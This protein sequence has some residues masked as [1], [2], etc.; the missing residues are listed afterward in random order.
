MLI[1][2]PD[3]LTSEQVDQC[4]TILDPVDH[5]VGSRTTEGSQPGRLKEN[6]QLP[7]NL[8]A[9]QEMGDM[10]LSALEQNALF[11]TAALPSR[12]FP[13][14]FHRYQGE[15]LF[16]GITNQAVRQVAGTPLR[17]RTDLS[18]MLFFSDPDEYEGGE[19]VIED[20]HGTHTA[21]LPAGH[22]VLYPSNSIHHIRPVTRGI[23]LSSFFWIQSMVRDDG[24]RS[25]LLDMD[26]AIQQLAQDQP[27]HASATRFNSIYNNLLRRWAE[28]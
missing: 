16:G 19:L 28:V 2:I 4:R 27:D 20:S 18:A 5:W 23:R 7:E 8:P 14:V 15:S 17:V 25:L 10:I 1:Q 3:I 6:M 22:M 11:M 26:L 21:R 9:A 24:Q 13:P 12:V